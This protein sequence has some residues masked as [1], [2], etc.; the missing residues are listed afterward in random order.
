MERELQERVIGAVVLVA[1][2][3]LIV[4]VF[5]DGTADDVEIISENVSLPGQ[6]PEQ[7]ATQKVVLN[8]DRTEPVP[9]NSPAPAQ[10]RTVEAEPEQVVEAPP[11][12]SPTVSPT[13]SPTAS[14]AAIPQPVTPPAVTS[15]TGMWAVQLGS[16]SQQENA[17]RLAASLRDQGYAAFLS[18]SETAAGVLHR[19]RVGPQKDRGGAEAVAAQ[20]GKSG[21]KG[22]VVPHP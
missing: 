6:N 4:P 8:R 14:P 22:Q 5:L 19:V 12:A 13:A 9:V 10:A 18:Q 15:A 1:V 7:P 21:H 11:A 2:A 16:F 3:V 17:N 20:L